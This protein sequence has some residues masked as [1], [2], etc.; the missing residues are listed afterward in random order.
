MESK[1]CKRKEGQYR[2]FIQTYDIVLLSIL[3]TFKIH[4]IFEK[5]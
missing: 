1:L 5:G 2:K 3:D 4:E